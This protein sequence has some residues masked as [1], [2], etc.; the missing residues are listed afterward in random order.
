[1]K[2][3]MLTSAAGQNWSAHFGDE[4]EMPTAEARRFIKARLAEKV[5]PEAA[6]AGA[7]ENAMRPRA[8]KG[9]QNEQF[10]DRR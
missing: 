1:M 8:R 9:A 2:V 6:V 7:S 4:I 5:K 3:R 10:I